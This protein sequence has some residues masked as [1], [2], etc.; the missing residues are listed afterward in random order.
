[1]TEPPI[2]FD[3]NKAAAEQLSKRPASAPR[4]ESSAPI[5][6]TT[7]NWRRL[8]DAKAAPE[9]EQLREWV[10]WFIGRYNIPVSVVP[11]C[12]WKH[13]ALVEE[14]AALHTAHDAAFY[15]SDNGFGPIGWH[16]RLTLALPRLSR[17]YSGGCTNGHRTIKPRTMP[18]VPGEE[19]WPAWT[20]R[21]HAY[22]AHPGVAN[23]KEE[24]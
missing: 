20:T 7:I 4:Q 24:Q 15:T 22:D 21:A 17:A 2:G 23:R 9:W 3:V 19:E 10:E 11:D 5:G 1:M 8:E 14:L 18:D 16:E 13:G 12:W 6:A